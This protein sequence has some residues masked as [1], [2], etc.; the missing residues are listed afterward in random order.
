MTAGPHEFVWHHTAPHKTTNWR[1]YITKQNWDPNKPLTRDQFEL[2]PFCTING[3]GQAPAMTKSMT[4]N[5]P[6]RTGYR[7]YLWRVG[8]CGYRKQ[9]L[10]GH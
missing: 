10:S 4:C 6:E 2:T 7:G 3:N 5:V 8:N 9:F 1:Y